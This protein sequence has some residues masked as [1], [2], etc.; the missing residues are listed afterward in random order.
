MDDL[1]VLNA[2]QRNPWS[3][4]PVGNIAD[5][6]SFVLLSDRTGGAQSRVFER[7][8]VCTDL[9]AP[10]SAVQ[11]GDLIDGYVDDPV[12]LS[13]QW[14]E[15]DNM[16]SELKTQEEAA[17]VHG[18]N[19]VGGLHSVVLPVARLGV[20]ARALFAFILIWGD[21]LT[22]PVLLR[23]QSLCPL[24]VGYSRRTLARI[25]STGGC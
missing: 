24:S 2:G 25:S 4:R 3:D 1:R 15:L 17:W 21:F 10:S 9:L 18:A 8:L 6:F 13:R 20:G 22:P 12:E 5:R 7:G 16:V 23:S 14:D 19:R 11:V